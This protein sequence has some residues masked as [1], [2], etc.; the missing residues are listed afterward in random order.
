MKKVYS[1]AAL[2]LIGGSLSAQRVADAPLRSF[3]PAISRTVSLER[4]SHPSQATMRDQTIVFSEDFSNGLDGNNGMGPWTISGTNGNVWRRTTTGT[5]GAYSSPNH[6]PLNSTTAS[7]GWM[8][9]DSDSAN[10]NFSVTPPVIISAPV[11]LV[12]SLSSPTLDLS[13][14][15]NVELRFYQR[16][17]YCCRQATGHYVEV[18]TDGGTTWPTRIPVDNHKAVYVDPNSDLAT[19]SDSG[20]RLYS[21]NLH[22]ALSADPGNVK[23]RFTQEGTTDN[24]LTHY[25]WQIDD[26][27]LVT[28]P[29]ADLK[30]YHASTT[31]WNGANSTYDSLP[32]SIFPI[33]ELRA[34]GLSMGYF[35]NSAGTAHNV[36]AKFSTDDGYSQQVSLGD[37]PVFSWDTAHAPAPG[38]MPTASVGTHTVYF[39]LSSDSI[40]ATPVNNAD[41]LQIS[42]SD[43]IYARDAN[44]LTSSYT[45]YGGATQPFK[46][47]NM[48][49]VNMNENLYGI[50]VAISSESDINFEMNAL[51]LDDN[52]ASLAETQ[53]HTILAEDT[54]PFGGNK[55]VSFIFDTPQSLTAGVDYFVCVQHFGGANAKIGESGISPARSSFLYSDNQPSG[56]GW[57]YTTS[58]PMVRMNFAQNIG[59]GA[60]NVS[61]GVGLGQN[62]PNPANTGSTR[63]DF[64]LDQ[65]APVT[66]ELR[67]VS[68]KLVKT[69][70]A[71]T[72]AQG[73]HHV[74]VN[75]ADLGA[76]V[77]FYTLTTGK[78]T[79]TKRMTVVR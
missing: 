25:F 68:G 17:R 47:G 16:M 44:R 48:F 22:N 59:I 51:L 11:K 72:M 57:Y 23:I 67:D 58:T 65:S 36:L 8:I 74:D 39:Q 42:V 38:W 6:N 64:S 78:N 77:Y 54:C 56:A 71:A 15:P 19:N 12:G 10:T 49:H 75:T 7:N 9:F 45:D 35:N 60:A 30:M 27:E 76:G 61:N 24:S 3:Q 26:V 31:F 5:I 50:D 4:S 79:S 34:R 20:S 28:L 55:F 37:V 53:Y 69:L 2:L 66:M 14:T 29:T 73:V 41:T 13:A 40:D 21:I 33:S 46:V 52:L 62:Y 63:I 70:V 1:L 43:F 32:Y 18:S